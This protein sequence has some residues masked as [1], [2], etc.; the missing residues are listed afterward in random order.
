MKMTKSVFVLS[1]LLSYVCAW[2][3]DPD[4]FAGSN[5]SS[6]VDHP[7]MLHAVGFVQDSEELDEY[8]LKGRLLAITD[9]C[10]V[11]VNLITPQHPN[12]KVVITSNGPKVLHPEHGSIEARST[13]IRAK[14][15]SWRGMV[16]PGVYG[17]GDIIPMQVIG[18]DQN[19][20]P[21][22]DCVV[23]INGGILD[24]KFTYYTVQRSLPLRLKRAQRY[25]ALR[26]LATDVGIT[27]NELLQSISAGNDEGL[28][29]VQHDQSNFV[30]NDNRL[31]GVE[32]YVFVDS[33]W[34]VL[35]KYLKRDTGGVDERFQ[36][37]ETEVNGKRELLGR[38]VDVGGELQLSKVSTT[39]YLSRGTAGLIYGSLAAVGFSSNPQEVNIGDQIAQCPQEKNLIVHVGG[40]MQD[41]E[42]LVSVREE[43]VPQEEVFEQKYQRLVSLA[44]Q[45]GVTL[46]EIY[47]T[48]R[49]AKNQA[50]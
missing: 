36:E 4:A 13:Y 7:V 39:G 18:F 47:T 35:V 44:S 5:S 23:S 24:E 28:T 16:N 50:H 1:L 48:L 9:W 26:G 12:Q 49:E 46:D 29:L 2:S 33:K 34:H 32:R 41:A 43:D 38:V 10:G 22:Q 3:A 17:Y 14:G 25:A 20:D 45:H 6:S 15:I 27:I 19:R 8:A 37:K 40:S 42:Y 30:Q 31:G 11:E 21:K